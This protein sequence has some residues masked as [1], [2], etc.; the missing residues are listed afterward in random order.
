M[1]C[2]GAV[3]SLLRGGRFYY[4]EPEEAE[5]PESQQRGATAD[6]ANRPVQTHVDLW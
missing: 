3:T 2:A 4:S 1:A 5:T 6:S